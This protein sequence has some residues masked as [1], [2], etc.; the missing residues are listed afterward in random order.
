MYYRKGARVER[1]IKKLFEENGF[2]VV[3]SAGSKG[4]TD[5]YIYNNVLALG[6]QVKARKTVGLYS[7]LGSADALVIK[8]D[9]QEPLIVM[10]LKTFLE[11]MNGERS[12]VRTF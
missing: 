12:S 9:R 2:K 5:L 8:A 3:R 11:A 1:E 7:L 4:E 10:S 6:I